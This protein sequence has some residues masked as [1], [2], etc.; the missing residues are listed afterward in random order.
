M[1]G[2]R[3]RRARTEPPLHHL[4]LARHGRTDP[5][6]RRD[7]VVE[8]IPLYELSGEGE[9]VYLRVRREGLTTREVQRRIASALA[10]VRARRRLRG[11]EGQ[12]IARATQ[13]FSVPVRTGLAEE[14][15]RPSRAR[16]ASRSSMRAA[17]G[18]SSGAGTSSATGSRSWSAARCPM[19]R[20]SRARRRRACSR[21]AARRTSSGSSVS[22]RAD[23]TRGA[24]SGGS[25]AARARGS[26]AW[27][28]RRGSRRSSTPGSSSGSPA[29]SSTA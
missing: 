1:A 22:A 27:S 14:V 3:P 16:P 18:T 8:E 10:L 6:P 24:A 20:R 29:A 13:T 28:S 4:R 11:P 15:A 12:A 21:I 5:P 2:L 23:G 26:R 9:H 19:R 25:R 7:F 17:T